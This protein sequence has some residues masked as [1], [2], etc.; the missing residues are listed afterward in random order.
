MHSFR[1]KTE[2]CTYTPVIQ[3]ICIHTMVS[4]MRLGDGFTNLSDS[5]MFPRPPP[6][7]GDHQDVFR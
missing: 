7:F 4:N 2:G 3:T 1:N 6:F 5:T